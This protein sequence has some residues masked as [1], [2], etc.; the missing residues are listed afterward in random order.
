MTREISSLLAATIEDLIS[1]RSFS[2]EIVCESVLLKEFF[3]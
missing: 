2:M 1:D 3:Y